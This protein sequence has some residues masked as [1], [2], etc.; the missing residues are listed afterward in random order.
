MNHYDSYFKNTDFYKNRTLGLFITNNK[1]KKLIKVLQ[2]NQ[3]KL[4]KN[5][6][7]K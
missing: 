5:V 7:T 4:K 1:E 6:K 2:D 3:D